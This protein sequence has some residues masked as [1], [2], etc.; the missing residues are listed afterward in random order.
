MKFKKL[1]K[2]KAKQ[3]EKLAKKIRAE[4]GRNFGGEG[5]DNIDEALADGLEECLRQ[6]KLMVAT[7]AE[8]E[9]RAHQEISNLQAQIA[10]SK[11]SEIKYFNEQQDAAFQQQNSREARF[12]EHKKEVEA[13][14]DLFRAG[15]YACATGT[16]SVVR[17]LLEGSATIRE[18]FLDLNPVIIAASYDRLDIIRL[19][20][21]YGANI[22]RRNARMQTALDVAE[23]RG[24]KDTITLLRTLQQQN[25]K[26][27]DAVKNNDI[28]LIAEFLAGGADCNDVDA[29]GMNSLQIA[30]LKQASIA[31]IQSLLQHYADV[32]YQGSFEKTNL[33]L[34]EAHPNKDVLLL[35]HDALQVA[36]GIETDKALVCSD[37]GNLL[38]GPSFGNSSG[39]DLPQYY[40]TLKTFNV[41]LNGKENMYLLGRWAGGILLYQAEMHSSAKTQP[42]K[43]LSDGPL[44]TDNCGWYLPQHYE[45]I[46][47]QVLDVD[48]RPTLLLWGRS[49][50]VGINLHAYHFHTNKWELLPVGPAWHHKQGWHKPENF[51]TI[52]G[53]KM[54]SAGRDK[55]YL[56]GRDAVLGIVLF[57]FDPQTKKWTPAAQGPAW[58]NNSGW[59]L[60]QH[61]ETI[62]G[63][64]VSEGKKD[65]LFVTGLSS[66]VGVNVW[67]FEPDQDRWQKLSNGPKLTYQGWD[68]EAHYRTLHSLSV[69]EN[70]KTCLYYMFRDVNGIQLWSFN[71]NQNKWTAKTLGPR[72]HSLHG[73]NEARHYNTFEWVTMPN[74]NSDLV[75]LKARADSGILL[76]VF[77]PRRNLWAALPTLSNF[78]A[79][80]GWSM[81]KYYE[82]LKLNVSQSGLF[83]QARDANQFRVYHYHLNPLMIDALFAKPN[84]VQD[85]VKQLLAFVDNQNKKLFELIKEGNLVPIDKHLQNFVDVGVRDALQRD[86]LQLAVFQNVHMNV[87]RRLVQAGFK[88]DLKLIEFAKLHK[89]EEMTNYLAS[90]LGL[91]SLLCKSLPDPWMSR[92][93]HHKNKLQGY[94]NTFPENSLQAM[95]GFYRFAYMEDPYMVEPYAMLQLLV[96]LETCSQDERKRFQ[97]LV[98]Q[99]RIENPK[100]ETNFVGP[101][102]HYVSSLE[103]EDLPSE[104]LSLIPGPAVSSQSLGLIPAAKTVSINTIR[105]QKEVLVTLQQIVARAKT[106]FENNLANYLTLNELGK[107]LAPAHYA[108]CGFQIKE[109]ALK[110]ALSKQKTIE[111]VLPEVFSDRQQ[112]N[113]LKEALTAFFA[114]YSKEVFELPAA[115]QEKFVNLVLQQQQSLT[116][117]HA[118]L[119][120]FQALNTLDVANQVRDAGL[121]LTHTPIDL[122]DALQVS[123]AFTSQSKEQL[124]KE[125]VIIAHDRQ[126]L[127]QACNEL[128]IKHQANLQQYDD[129]H[130]LT[131]MLDN[132]IA[133]E[134]IRGLK[135]IYEAIEEARENLF[136]EFRHN[137]RHLEHRIMDKLGILAGSAF[138]TFTVGAPLLGSLGLKAGTLKLAVAQGMLNAGLQAGFSKV[139]FNKAL[140][141]I[142]E[143]GAMAGFAHSF[144]QY[145]KITEELTLLNAGKQTMVATS[146]GAISALIHHQPLATSVLSIMAGAMASQGAKMAGNHFDIPV[147][148]PMQH[149]VQS[150]GQALMRSAFTKAARGRNLSS[151]LITAGISATA[152]AAADSLQPSMESSSV[153]ATQKALFALFEKS[154]STN[155]NP[156][157]RRSVGLTTQ[158]STTPNKN[159]MPATNA[160]TLTAQS[161]TTAKESLSALFEEFQEL[162]RENYDWEFIPEREWSWLDLIASAVYAD[163][164]PKHGKVK[165][166]PDF[167]YRALSDLITKNPD[168][169]GPRRVTAP[170]SPSRPDAT[171]P[172][173]RKRLQIPS[174][175]PYDSDNPTLQAL[176]RT[177]RVIERARDNVAGL[178]YDWA[179]YPIENIE[180]TLLFCRD[181]AEAVNPFWATSP[182]AARRNQERLDG[183]VALAQAFKQGDSTERAEIIGE[184]GLTMLFSGGM[185][186]LAFSKNANMINT[187]ARASHLPSKPM[188]FSGGLKPKPNTSSQPITIK[189][190]SSKSPGVIDITPAGLQKA[191]STQGSMLNSYKQFV[192]GSVEKTTLSEQLS[193]GLN[194]KPPKVKTRGPVEKSLTQVGLH[195]PEPLTL[196]EIHRVKQWQGAYHQHLKELRSKDVSTFSLQTQKLLVNS[197]ADNAIKTRMV[198]DDLAGILKEH[199]G[200]KIYDKNG[201]LINHMTEWMQAKRAISKLLNPKLE[202]SIPSRLEK[203]YKD[204][205][206][207]SLEAQTLR[208]KFNE[209][210]KIKDLYNEL[211]R[212][213][214][215][216]AEAL[217]L[218]P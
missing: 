24:A 89:R 150:A 205:K 66:D 157:E 202:K 99:Y 26:L 145:L 5:L 67:C 115:E 65:R 182:G 88:I 27:R 56:M 38:N 17:A 192:Q 112:C 175:L 125:E 183:L 193:A 69:K 4:F 93:Q 126:K 212:K 22:S 43:R 111:A 206:Y 87:M 106:F 85:A 51:K 73:W 154:N 82:T 103:R 21:S 120:T 176:I 148:L 28:K 209:L 151:A 186:S 36:G 75:I 178:A 48:G 98:A 155:A 100:P 63:I 20:A 74:G 165:D 57:C 144:S 101:K 130:S 29:E 83:L 118:I 161:S 184:L 52:Q 218:E 136:E 19:L 211:T 162:R 166:M 40:K 50:D 168:S 102:Q 187:L 198:P 91:R 149:F 142:I 201:K 96:S 137:R 147:S 76:N 8:E 54:R 167:N 170:L 180:E 1:L 208:E 32:E 169:H 127:V 95:I 61:F 116:S 141:A 179:T 60:S 194:I 216:K 134:A 113:L 44:W 110:L 108:K 107:N 189:V 217:K 33:Q 41:S 200:I 124:Q 81:P 181:M 80:N 109:A 94:L 158:N 207:D 132:K 14:L 191:A 90:Q 68:Y 215:W 188:V 117:R 25:Q 11:Q 9:A 62:Q 31:V 139:S 171:V 97:E 10:Q 128:L 105:K 163:Q 195:H 203:L 152:E 173:P 210:S 47:C 123:Q 122:N 143:G 140:K 160:G 16:I 185:G 204:G 156:F 23:R 30:L 104:S 164:A 199:R 71:P 133:E 138:L 70:G 213:P 35:I 12:A 77:C 197:K 13:I 86:A 153:A 59:H 174:S 190:P 131:I 49:D 7:L 196:R 15:L 6:Q 159:N 214:Q 78:L 34:A 84:D 37:L 18:A 2:K 39:W 92:F 121:P 55:L 42:W 79:V 114:L 3:I 53:F 135:L 46:N 64:V 172:Q 177:G 146:M 119:R 129:A 72:W 58:N 45:T